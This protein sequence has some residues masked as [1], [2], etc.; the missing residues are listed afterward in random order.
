[1]SVMTQSHDPSPPPAT[2]SSADAN[3]HAPYPSEPSDST[4]AIR[5]DSSSSMTAIKSSLDT[6][7]PF[8]DLAADGGAGDNNFCM[9]WERQ[10]TIHECYT[11]PLWPLGLDHFGHPD[12]V[13]Q[14]S[15]TH[16]AHGRTAM[17]FDRDLAYSQ[18]AGYLLVHLAGRDQQHYLLFAGRQRFKPL[19]HLRNIVV[20]FPPLSIAFDGGHHG[21]KHV[22]IAK[23]LGK[24]V[25]RAPLHG[26]NRHGNVA[27]SSHHHNR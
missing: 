2:N 20:S 25:H 10:G 3:P 12:E 26:S 19:V 15:R 1:M 6:H 16:F 21:V 9:P 4:S 23:W 22:L 8:P 13:G 27:I 17:N 7:R 11:R 5:S 24:K 14:G 18:I